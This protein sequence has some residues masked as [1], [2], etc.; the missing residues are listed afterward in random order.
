MPT[1]VI[2]ENAILA[3]AINKA[4]RLAPTKGEAFDKAAGI[5]FDVNPVSRQAIIRVTDLEVSFEQEIPI[6][7]GKGDPG[8]WRLPAQILQSFISTLPMGEGQT[9]DFIHRGD[10]AIRFKAGRTI[11]KLNMIAGPDI[12]Q[13]IFAW[14]D[15]PLAQASD[16]A[17]KIEQVSWCCDRKSSSMLSGVHIDGEYLMGCDHASLAIIPCQVPVTEPV[18]VPLESLAVILK[19]ASHCQIRALRKRFQIAL[20][21]NTRVTSGILE[22][23]YPQVKNVMRENFLG[24]IKVHRQAF[25]D[26]LNRMMVLARNEKLPTLKIDIDAT[27]L[28]PALTFDMDIPGIGRMQDT[29]DVSTENFQDRLELG[30]LPSKLQSAVEHT[31]GDY[32][33]IDFGHPEPERSPLSSIHIRDDHGYRCYLMPK[34]G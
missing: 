19:S 2:F 5:R 10:E 27:G 15:G 22:G 21:E 17:F 23:S 20:D 14:E 33:E 11:A 34:K 28:V 24:T 6:A 30:M 18:T 9:V 16:L 13:E 1:T 12:P 8:I 29:I 3:D 32:F 4:T 26:T 25:I 7:E 31:K